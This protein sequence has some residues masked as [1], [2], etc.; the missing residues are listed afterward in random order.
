MRSVADFGPELQNYLEG[1]EEDSEDDSEEDSDD[2][3]G[4]LEEDEEEHKMVLVVRQDLKMGKGKIGAQCGHATL[5]A[6]KS[7]LMK[8][9]KGSVGAARALRIWESLGQAKVVVQ[10]KTEEDMEAVVACAK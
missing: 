3:E 10:V 6:Y 8:A 2:S 1:D 7:L 4:E 9:N 5:G